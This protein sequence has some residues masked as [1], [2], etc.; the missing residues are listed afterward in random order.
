MLLKRAYGMVIAKK[1][2]N[3]HQKGLNK[4]EKN[5]NNTIWRKGWIKT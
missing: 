1:R 5:E 4:G 2:K 3:E